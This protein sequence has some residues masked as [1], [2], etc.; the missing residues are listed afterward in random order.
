MLNCK[1]QLKF[2]LVDDEIDMIALFQFDFSAA[3][4]SIRI[5]IHYIIINKSK[6]IFLYTFVLPSKIDSLKMTDEYINT[7]HKYMYMLCHVFLIFGH[8]L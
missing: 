4:Q 3:L 8:P 5:E 1:K 2:E 6:P 7:L